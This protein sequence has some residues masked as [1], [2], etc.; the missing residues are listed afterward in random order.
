M[1]TDA[2]APRFIRLPEVKDRTGRSKSE[3]YR[4]IAAK[5]F[6]ASHRQSHRLAVWYEHEV[7]AWLS[8]QMVQDARLAA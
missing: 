7:V 2:P 1:R 5:K 4:L 3:I 8:E 6:P